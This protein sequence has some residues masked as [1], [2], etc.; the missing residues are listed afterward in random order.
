MAPSGASSWRAPA[1]DRT[2]CHLARRGARR[3]RF[4]PGRWPR[5]PCRPERSPGPVTAPST[6]SSR[7]RHRCPCRS[8]SRSRFHPRAAAAAAGRLDRRHRRR[9]PPATASVRRAGHVLLRHHPVPLVPRSSSWPLPSWSPAGHLWP[10]PSVLPHPSSTWPSQLSS[11]PLPQISA[12]PG[13]TAALPSS[14]SSHQRWP[15][16]SASVAARHTP[17]AVDERLKIGGALGDHRR[18]RSPWPAE[19]APPSPRRADRCR[20][21]AAI[22]CDQLSIQPWSSPTSHLPAGRRSR[23]RTWRAIRRRPARSSICRPATAPAWPARTKNRSGGRSRPPGRTAPASRRSRRCHWA[24]RRSRP[25]P[26]RRCRNCASRRSSRRRCS[27]APRPPRT[28]PSPE[29]RRWRRARQILAV[30][31]VVRRP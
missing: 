13:C 2:R 14:H 18:A 10:P 6:E 15:S 27:A 31:K 3:R 21:P 28:S 12:A 9:R 11:T 5:A 17:L 23:R 16:P 25:L 26:D 30:W 19:S 22:C 20:P 29:G 8:S 4:V 7:S 1:S 24:E